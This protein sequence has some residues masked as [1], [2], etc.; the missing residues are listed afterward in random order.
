MLVQINADPTIANR[1]VYGKLPEELRNPKAKL[2]QAAM[3]GRDLID[4]GI[5]NGDAEM[6]RKG[7]MILRKSTITIKRHLCRD[8]H[9]PAPDASDPKRW[10]VLCTSGIGGVFHCTP[11]KCLNCLFFDEQNRPERPTDIVGVISPV[12][13]PENAVVLS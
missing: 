4:D 2:Y 10:E 9:Y 1:Q 12:P 13:Q 5:L 6:T 7:Q 8:Y 11:L 3:S